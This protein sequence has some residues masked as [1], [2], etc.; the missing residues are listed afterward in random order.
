MVR[1]PD[2]FQKPIQVFLPEVGSVRV[3]NSGLKI[4]DSIEK[5][6]NDIP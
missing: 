6:S 1:C 2:F 5:I 3:S 4:Q